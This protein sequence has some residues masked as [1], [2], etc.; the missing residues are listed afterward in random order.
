M[1][2]TR[3]QPV[4]AG[5]GLQMSRSSADAVFESTVHANENDLLRYFQRRL[6]NN[7]DAADAFGELLLIAWKLRRRVPSDPTGARM[8]L[9]A[10]ARNVLRDS[11]RTLARR[12]AAVDRLKSDI[13]T[14][15]APAWDDSAMEVRDALNRLPED[16]AE[17]IRLTYWEG[18][19][20]HEVAE[21]LRINPSTVRS[22]LSRAKDQLRAALGDPES[23]REEH[24]SV[25]TASV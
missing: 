2:R 4:G 17:L 20:S 21:V 10:T 18:L 11:R 8:W 22:R 14:L 7:A 3:G 5:D 24:I 12:S 15:A 13:H 25:R 19:R 6:P 16:D 9:F 23:D 1:A